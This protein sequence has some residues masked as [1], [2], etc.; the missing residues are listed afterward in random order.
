MN[1]NTK[2]NRRMNSEQDRK[3]WK[4][5]N[6]TKMNKEK[7]RKNEHWKRKRIKE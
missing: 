6:D 2:E 1:R 5:M 4:Q 7:D 3:K